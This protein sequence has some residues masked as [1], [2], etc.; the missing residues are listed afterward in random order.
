MQKTQTNKHNRMAANGLWLIT[1]LF[2]QRTPVMITGYECSNV[3]LSAG[4]FVIPEAIT[5]CV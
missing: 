4:K 1:F 3:A 2:V 5:A